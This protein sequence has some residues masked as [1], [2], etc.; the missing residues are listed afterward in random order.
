MQYEIEE[1]LM[2]RKISLNLGQVQ[3]DWHN[4][5]I[6]KVL[7]SKDKILGKHSRPKTYN[8]LH[9]PI[10]RNHVLHSV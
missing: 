3:L 10:L 1:Y 5:I 9:P 4:I 2:Q 8:F 6:N 7:H